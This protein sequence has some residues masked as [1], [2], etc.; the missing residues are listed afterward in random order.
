MKP[1]ME[2]RTMP[3]TAPGAG[4]STLYTLGMTA[5]PPL[6]CRLNSS[7]ACDSEVGAC[8]IRLERRA[9]TVDVYAERRGKRSEMEGCGIGIG[10]MAVAGEALR[11]PSFKSDAK[12]VC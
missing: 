8:G 4:P 3:A 5:V 2:P 10:A 12:N 1:A 6:L 9:A 7:E 11:P